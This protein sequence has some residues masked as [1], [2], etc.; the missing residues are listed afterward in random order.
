M[1]PS[2]KRPKVFLRADFIGGW[3]WLIM[4]LYVFAHANE[5]MLTRGNDIS[6]ME[7]FEAA[8]GV[9][10]VF[11]MTYVSF[12]IPH[13]NLG[14]LGKRRLFLLSILTM[15]LIELICHSTMNRAQVLGSGFFLAA[16]TAAIFLR[17]M[18]ITLE[19]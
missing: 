11:A 12:E 7:T 18:I 10:G 13:E 1:I 4:I 9:A 16:L 8:G 17:Y 6:L 3:L 15:G 14:A 19:S 5:G 2:D